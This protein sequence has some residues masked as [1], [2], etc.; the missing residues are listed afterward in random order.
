MARVL[1]TVAGS[2]RAAERERVARG[3]RIEHLDRDAEVDEQMR[4]G[5]GVGHEGE[6][7][8]ATV[9]EAPDA[10]RRHRPRPR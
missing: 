9:V 6:R 10:R 3:L 1:L 7:D 8:D 5:L 2:C 4:A